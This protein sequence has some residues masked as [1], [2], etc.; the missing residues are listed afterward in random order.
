MTSFDEGAHPHLL[1]AGILSTSTQKSLLVLVLF[2]PS[3]CSSH[4]TSQALCSLVKNSP[5]VAILPFL[6]FALLTTA[7]EVG[8][9]LAARDFS[10]QKHQLAAGVVRAAAE[11]L[12]ECR[13]GG[14]TSHAERGCVVLS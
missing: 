3:C 13:R 9:F 5:G 11:Q 2:H 6:V 7:G 14:C 10:Q 8:V 12:S 1:L 4:V